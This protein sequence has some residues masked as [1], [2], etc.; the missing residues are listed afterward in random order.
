M[1]CSLFFFKWPVSISS[2]ECLRF[3]QGNEVLWYTMV[4]GIGASRTQFF[5][6]DSK[7]KRGLLAKWHLR[8]VFS[9]EKTYI[10]PTTINRVLCQ[11]ILNPYWGFTTVDGNL[12]AQVVCVL[13]GF[14]LSYCRGFFLKTEWGMFS[15]TGEEGKASAVFVAFVGEQHHLQR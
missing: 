5:S 3:C 14:L 13:G 11:E 9:L 7:S 8:P 15:F 4:L 10:F 6:V 12:W 2:S 1:I